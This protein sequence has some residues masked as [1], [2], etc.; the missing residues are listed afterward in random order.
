ML[1]GDP[2]PSVAALT[3]SFPPRTWGSGWPWSRSWACWRPLRLPRLLVWL[4]LCSWRGGVC[5]GLGVLGG[6]GCCSHGHSGRDWAARGTGT[7][8][9][10]CGAMPTP[11]PGQAAPPGLA[12]EGA[13]GSLHCAQAKFAQELS[14]V[15]RAAPAPGGVL[16]RGPTA[17]PGAA[18]PLRVHGGL[19]PEREARGDAARLL[20][21]SQNDYRIDPNQELL[22]LGKRPLGAAAQGEGIRPECHRVSHSP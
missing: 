5:R 9:G 17:V 6:G 15:P 22:A 10:S 4:L 13:G 18:G 12:G 19:F 20:S 8:E 14:V 7:Q 11:S 2:P 3:A 1:W 21:A 16:G